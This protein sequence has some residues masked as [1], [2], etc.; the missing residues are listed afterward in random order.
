MEPFQQARHI[1]RYEKGFRMQIVGVNTNEKNLVL[2]E[3]R[4]GGGSIQ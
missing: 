1:Q 3:E 2:Y 4:C